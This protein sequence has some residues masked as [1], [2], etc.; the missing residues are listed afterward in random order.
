MKL[1]TLSWDDNK[2]VNEIKD[3]NTK[4]I[5]NRI[6]KWS[7]E[8]SWESNMVHARMAWENSDFLCKITYLLILF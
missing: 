2:L 4:W 1:I 7:L 8:L 3:E 6:R 5:Y